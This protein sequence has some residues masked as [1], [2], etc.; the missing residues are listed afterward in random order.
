M[1]LTGFCVTSFTITSMRTLFIFTLALCVCCNTKEDTEFKQVSIIPKPVRVTQTKGTLKLDGKVAIISKLDE[2]RK[3]AELLSE[4]LQAAGIQVGTPE[5]SKHKITLTRAY[6]EKG[7]KLEGYLLTVD[8]QGIAI[9]GYT[10]AGLFYGAQTLMQLLPTEGDKT[11]PYVNITDYP[12]FN[13]RGLH[14]DVGRHMFPVEFIKKYIDVMARHKFNKFHWHLTEDQGW[15]IEIKKYPK[16]QEVAA[17]RDQTVIGLASTRTRNEPH[18]F[19][20]KKYGG[21][22][23]QEQVKEVVAY[24]AAHYI[25]V[26]PE[27][28]LPGHATAALA[29]YP[30]L[31]CNN[32]EHK[33]A[34]TWGIFP[35]VYCAGKEETF[36]FLENVMDEII[37]LF[38]SRYVHIGGDEVFNKYFKTS[39]E[40]C[41][42]CKKR[43]KV[44]NLKDVKE[45]QSYF[46]QRM[47]KYL[48]S[49]GKTIIGWDEIL[50]GGLAENA[51]V[52]SW[53]GEEGG[54]AAAK[55]KHDVIMSPENWFY[56]DHAQ[57]TSG[58]EPLTHA[59]FTPLRETYSYDPISD[60][61]TADESKYILGVQGN[62]WTEY[63][64][65]SDHVEYMTY[66]RACAI[67]E[68]GW[69]PKENRSYEDFVARMKAHTKRLAAWNVNY[70]KH[71]EK[72]FASEKK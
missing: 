65:T 3:V 19:D 69:S 27:I 40:T 54:I 63:M 26:I 64:K 72:E 66:P 22:Y 33:T 9:K 56:L 2:E 70:A 60:S 58:K 10:G 34:T 47:E 37:P 11:L 35:D 46:V 51:T 31:S 25:E 30:N 67:A 49:K 50:E 7:S 52:M 55:Q 48:N 71:I 59:G 53:R 13:Y 8:E 42:H 12:R 39:W 15:R 16:L 23:T 41:A 28:E 1:I 38:P 68:I 17:F 6:K 5:E 43:M 14:L 44:E 36:T 18:D 20:G 21:Y 62:V 45:L 4:Q 57:D 32:G 24:A 61:L 29:A